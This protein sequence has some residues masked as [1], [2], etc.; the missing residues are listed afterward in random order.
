MRGQDKQ[1]LARGPQFIGVARRSEPALDQA[2]S[3]DAL[4]SQGGYINESWVFVSD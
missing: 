3:S 2:A 4:T 1:K